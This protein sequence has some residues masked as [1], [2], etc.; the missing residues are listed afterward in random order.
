MTCLAQN[1]FLLFIFN[2]RLSFV[3]QA[4]LPFIYTRLSCGLLTTVLSFWW[5]CIFRQFSW[6]R[7][8]LLVSCYAKW[9]LFAWSI[10]HYST[11]YCTGARFVHIASYYHANESIISIFIKSKYFKKTQ[12]LG[13]NNKWIMFLVAQQHNQ[14]LTYNQVTYNH[15]IA[16]SVKKLYCVDGADTIGSS[17][18]GRNRFWAHHVYIFDSQTY[19]NE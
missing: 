19:W 15:S 14:V 7:Q 10:C 2:F 1:H 6:S 4:Y 17:D 5:D 13:S 12:F 11:L 8:K 18:L 9:T 3:G 16:T